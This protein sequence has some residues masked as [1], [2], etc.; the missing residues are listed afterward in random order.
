[1]LIFGIILLFKSK[2]SINK[3]NPSEISIAVLPFKNYSGNPDLDPF[4]DGITDEVISRL[5]KIKSLSKVTSFTSVL[6]YKK[7]EKGILEIANELGVNNILEGNFQK[8]GDKIKINLRL[9]HGPSGIHFWS[10]AYLVDWQSKDIFT[11]QAEVAELV[12]KQL[13]ADISQEELIDIRKNSTNNPQAYEYYLRGEYKK[14]GLSLNNVLE[15]I[16]YLEKAIEL[17]SLFIEPYISIYGSYIVLGGWHGNL[18]KEKADSLGLPYFEK[19]FRLDPDNIKLLSGL[20]NSNYYKWNFKFAD[21]LYKVLRKRGFK[22]AYDQ[23]INLMFGRNDLVIKNARKLFRE[24]PYKTIGSHMTCAYA[25]Y[26]KGQIDST[27]YM[28]REG[29]TNSSI[30]R[31]VLRPFWKFIHRNGRL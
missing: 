29:L 6:R 2:S 18:S 22:Y 23:H 3:K 30:S 4:C 17:D 11:I 27:L 12:A 10:H 19:A 7:L 9:T 16:K 8:S 20:A 5:A 24:D 31:S 28:I 13:D 26:Y 21:S 14:T 15:S 25:Y 1:M